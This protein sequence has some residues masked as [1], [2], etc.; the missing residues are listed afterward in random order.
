M[1]N[2]GGAAGECPECGSALAQME[3]CA[4]CPCCGHASCG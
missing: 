4:M 1:E 3:G 2:L